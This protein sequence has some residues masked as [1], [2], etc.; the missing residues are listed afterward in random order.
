MHPEFKVVFA[1]TSDF[2]VPALD[3]LNT[4][5]CT[6]SLVVTQP[7]RSKGRGRHISPPPVKICALKHDNPLLQPETVRTDAFYD[8]I[9][10]ARPEVMVVAAFGH[11]LPKRILEIPLYGAVNI[12][13][14]LLPRY[15]GPAPIQW[16]VINGDAETGVTTM[17]MDKGMDTGEILLSAKTPILPE[18]TAGTLHDRLAGMGA[19]LLIK[20]LDAMRAGA[21][22][23]LPQAHAQATYAP[24]LTKQDG[25]ID[26]SLDA[27]S[28]ERRVRGLTPWP[29]AYTYLNGRMIKLFTVK[30][31]HTAVDEPPGTVVK[32]GLRHL[33]VAAGS[34]LIAV[35]EVQG[36]S[37]KRLPVHE[38]L[39]GN[40]IPKN[41]VFS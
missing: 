11:I 9:A 19:D 23:P 16:A 38:Y 17:L 40:P 27:A 35:E 39:K 24:M 8:A 18:D 30:P 28:I 29:G 37:G 22:R 1:G 41:A 5:D 12:H 34:G 32:G 6:V 7:D 36:A 3:A 33:H 31:I 25:H 13:A 21:L 4:Y 10:R 26:W 14:S 20:T 15:R 2:A